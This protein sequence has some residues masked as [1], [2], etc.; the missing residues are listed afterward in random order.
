M[1]E[2]VMASGAR[3]TVDSGRGVAWWSESW[4]LFLKNP[5][6]WLVFGL[7]ALVGFI[8]LNFVPI[9]GGLAAAVLA[10]VLV[11]A[12][13]LCA[14]K[15]D[16]G[17]S[18]DVNDLLDVFKDKEKLTPL[19][20]L[21]VLAAVGSLVIGIAVAVLG[22]G[23]LFGLVAGAGV[24]STGGMMA[25]AALGMLAVLI[26]LAMGFVL[27]M[28]LW[29]A[30]ALVAFQGLTPVDALKA[31]WSASL[32]NIIPFLVYGL[33]WI[34]GAVIASLPFMLGWLLLAPLTMLGIYVSYKDI[35]GLAPT[36]VL[37]PDEQ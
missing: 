24:R 33:I 9:I 18:I 16:S 6:M 4:M 34:V 15:L 22:G 14:R 3:R 26:G 27:G 20:V 13:V 28:A 10:Q 12:W 29:F 21:G 36:I 11:G 19:L 25:G 35:F 32:A 17:E 37:A 31:S 30:A 8:V 5:G 2:A 1:E 23:A 7:I